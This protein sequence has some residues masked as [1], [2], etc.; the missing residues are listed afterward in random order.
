[1][2]FGQVSLCPSS[3]SA[4]VEFE[5]MCQTLRIPRESL[6]LLVHRRSFREAAKGSR[7]TKSSIVNATF[8]LV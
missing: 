6:I 1:M 3:I 2:E 4:W 8:G 5:C 7:K